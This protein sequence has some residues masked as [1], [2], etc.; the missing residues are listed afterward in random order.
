MAKDRFGYGTNQNRIKGDIMAFMMREEGTKLVEQAL[1]EYDQPT[2]RLVISHFMNTG[3]YI[4]KE[5][6]T[7][8]VHQKLKQN[9]R[10]IT[11]QH[12]WIDEMAFKK[13]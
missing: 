3:E 12:Q 9:T 11:G 6:M 2:A 10:D 5:S 8:E 4:G 7:P 1:A 13:Y